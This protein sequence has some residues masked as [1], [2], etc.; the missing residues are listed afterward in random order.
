M[1]MKVIGFNGS[2]R[3]N[4]NTAT[5]VS[6]V[7]KGAESRG[8]TVR[9]VN[10]HE[11]KMKGC[12]G[13]EACKED[14]GRCVQNDDLSPILQEL[15]EYDA[16]VLGTPIYWWHVN[17][18]FKML[19]DRFYC[20]FAGEVNCETGEVKYETSFPQGKKFVV[21]TS[22]GEKENV[23]FFPELYGYLSEW[24]KMLTTLMGASSTEFVFHCGSLWSPARKDADLLA[25]AEAIG[26]SLV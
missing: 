19:T 22:R 17:P 16:I 23:K 5:L 18:Q 26:A 11:L 7:L 8:A 20:Y 25:R 13:C 4:G 9:L 21:V 24:L 15:G 3:K 2:P 6:A 14:P 10:L 12:Q 1:A